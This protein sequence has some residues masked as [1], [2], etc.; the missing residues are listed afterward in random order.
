MAHT[1][2]DIFRLTGC[3]IIRSAAEHHADLDVFIQAVRIGSCLCTGNHLI[4]NCLIFCPCNI[5][6]EILRYSKM[7]EGLYRDQID[8]VYDDPQFYPVAETVKQYLAIAV[9]EINHLSG[10]PALVM[11]RQIQG[12]LVMRNCDHR[13][14]TI[15]NN[16]IDQILIKLQSLFI[17]LCLIAMRENSRPV[18]RCTVGL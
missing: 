5:F 12:H 8:L 6:N 10:I 2:Q 9:E 17:R 15:G 11:R 14:H 7:V 16:F 1:C 4:V 13:F 18:D 3:R